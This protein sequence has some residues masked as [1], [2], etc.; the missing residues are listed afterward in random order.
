[1]EHWLVT[2]GAGQND[3]VLDWAARHADGHAA[4]EVIA[5]GLEVADP[6]AAIL[7]AASRLQA[8]CPGV[9]RALRTVP[10]SVAEELA[11][12]SSVDLVVLGS[13]CGPLNGTETDRMLSLL[14][15][16]RSP[17][18]LVPGEGC[19][20]DAEPRVI[21]WPAAGGRPPTALRAAVQSGRDV[22]RVERA[23]IPSPIGARP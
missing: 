4:L 7:R 15:A 9:P 18:V 16:C 5:S 21:V 6:R 22:V 19:A 12:S 8:R 11:G 14:G 20:D 2:L 23:A 3:A 17:V 10:R 13:P 1:M